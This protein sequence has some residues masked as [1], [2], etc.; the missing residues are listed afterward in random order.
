MTPNLI[1]PISSDKQIAVAITLSF[2][3]CNRNS[4][5][6]LGLGNLENLENGKAFSSQWKVGEF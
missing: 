5:F 3:Y 2:R 4:G 6:P 1:Q